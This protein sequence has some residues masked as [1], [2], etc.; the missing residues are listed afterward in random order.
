[1]AATLGTERLLLRAWRDEDFAPFAALNADPRVME[2]YPRTLTQAESNKLAAGIRTR[3]DQSPFAL[4]AVELRETGAFLGYVG[5]AVPTFDAHF[6]PCVEIGWRLAFGY[7]NKGYATEAAQAVK[8]HAFEHLALTELVSFTS[9]KSSIPASDGATRDAARPGR[10][11]RPSC[12]AHA[13]LFM[14][15]RAVP[16]PSRER[17]ISP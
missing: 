9:V 14:P 6:T 15:S 8:T 12:S 17:V 11:F 13:S 16:P 3:L 7:W 5:L 1:M 2:F 10:R 4:W